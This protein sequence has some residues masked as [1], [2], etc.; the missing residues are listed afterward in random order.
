M[1]FRYGAWTG[2][3][4]GDPEFLK[5]LLKLYH[6]LLLQTN[7]DVDEALDALEQI[8]ERYGFFDKDFDIEN[9]KQ[10]L[11]QNDAVREVEPGK[12]VLTSRGERAIRH[13]SLQRDLLPDGQVGRRRSPRAARGH[14]R[15]PPARDAPLPVR[16]RPPTSIPS[17]RSATPSGAA[18]STTSA[19]SEDDLEVYETEHL[20]SCAT[21]LLLDVSHSMIL[22]GEDRIT[23]A[24]QRRAGADRAD[25]HA[26]SQ[27]HARRRPVRRR[28][29]RGPAGEAALR[30]GR[31]VPHEHQG[32]PAAGA[33]HPGAAQDGE[34]ADLHD[35]RRQ[36]VVHPRERAAVQEPVRPRSQDRQPHARRGRL[37]PAQGHPD[38]HLHGHRRP[39]AHG[40]RRPLH[41]SSTTAARSTPTSRT[42]AATCSRTS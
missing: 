17:A 40:V 33:A 28:R 19:W 2:G 1:K 34:Q 39:R 14:G 27:G 38:H 11:K 8:G 24:K 42:W 5:A 7:G 15:R 10:R 32:G 25:H 21:V 22:Y 26:L 30:P 13:D 35:H 18:A 37:V 3:A 31:P 12:H 36:A 41:R 23:P 20:T 9:F 29:A 6:Q 4:F 16:R